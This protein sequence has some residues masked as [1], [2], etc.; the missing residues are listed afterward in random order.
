MRNIFVV[1]WL[2]IEVLLALRACLRCICRPHKN[3]RCSEDIPEIDFNRRFFLPLVQW[4]HGPELS[5]DFRQD[6]EDVIHILISIM[7]S[8]GKA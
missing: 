4:R 3:I 5:H 7:A 8:Q 1:F 6:V 2:C